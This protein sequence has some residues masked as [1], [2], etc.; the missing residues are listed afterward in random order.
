MCYSCSLSHCSPRHRE[1]WKEK[2]EWGQRRGET[3]EIS[4]IPR[5][6][7]VLGKLRQCK[8]EHCCL[9]KFYLDEKASNYK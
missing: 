7:F 2:R 1:I 3:D 4:H 8:G 9:P 5:E 6:Q